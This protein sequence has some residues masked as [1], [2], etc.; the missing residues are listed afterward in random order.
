MN[1]VGGEVTFSLLDL[2]SLKLSGRIPK[3]QHN[4][5]RILGLFCIFGLIF[6]HLEVNL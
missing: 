6:P 1:D 4:E 3:C 5:V 2:V